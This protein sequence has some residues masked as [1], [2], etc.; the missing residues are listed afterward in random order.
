MLICAALSACVPEDKCG[1]NLYYDSVN[2]TCRLCPKDA[3]LKNDTCE[4]K[5][6]E[7][8]EFVG[9]VCKL[10]DGATPPGTGA[11]GASG[12]GGGSS[13]GSAAVVGQCPDYCKLVSACVGENSL[14]QAV[15]KDVISS[16]HADD[17]SA[18]K[19]SCEGTLDGDGSSDPVVQ[20]LAGA[21]YKCPGDAMKAQDEFAS[22]LTAIGGC[23]GTNASNA[24][25][26]EICKTLKA[27]S[28]LSSRVEFCP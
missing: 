26:K 10:K 1:G 17:T 11:A 22:G 5:D 18:C 7:N 2:K 9:Y 3:N 24:L 21:T 4:C 13:G 14:A 25:C 15:F 28:T 8:Y 12:G 27:N 16:L 20:C 23:C 6:S 19:A